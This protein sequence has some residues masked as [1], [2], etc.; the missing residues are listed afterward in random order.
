MK[1]VPVHP[2]RWHIYHAGYL[3]GIAS[4]FDDALR[5]AAA[6]AEA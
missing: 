6:Y 1:I 4:R 5:F 2:G 3:V